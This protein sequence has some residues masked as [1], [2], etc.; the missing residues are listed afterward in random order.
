MTSSPPKR[1]GPPT[2]NGTP[3]SVNAWTRWPGTAPRRPEPNGPSP[4]PTGTRSEPEPIAAQRATPWCSTALPS[5]TPGAAGRAS[6]H[7]STTAPPE[8][9]SSRLEPIRAMAWFAWRQPAQHAVPTLAMC[10]PMGRSQTA[11]AIALI[12]HHWIL[13]KTNRE[14][15]RDKVGRSGQ[16]TFVLLSVLSTALKPFFI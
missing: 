9:T 4:A 12:R 10:F 11:F 16:D 3:T 14:V 15:M 13:S 2:P 6:R 7:R 1:S 8:K 5:S